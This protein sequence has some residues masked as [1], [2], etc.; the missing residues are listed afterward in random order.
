MLLGVGMFAMP[1]GILASG[2]AQAVKSRDFVVS[3]N[4]V[5]GVP[6]FSKLEAKR[7]AEIVAL[8][9]PTLAMPGESIIRKGAVADRMF[10]ISSGEVLVETPGQ[11][12]DLHAGDFFGEIALLEERP[13]TADVV[14]ITSCQLLELEARDFEELLLSNPDL[15]A[16]IN[17][18]AEARRAELTEQN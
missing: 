12:V 16:D 10:F 1:A 15:A 14:A 4:M 11:P 7:I 8:L 5:A 6:L 2:F 3:W 17:R 18:V 13:R 9:K